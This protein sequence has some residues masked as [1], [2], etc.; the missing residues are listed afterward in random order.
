MWVGGILPV[1][2]GT[3]R[4]FGNRQSSTCTHLC[5]VCVGCIYLATFFVPLPARAEG[6]VV[7]CNTCLYGLPHFLGAFFCFVF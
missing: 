6:C 4:V 2:V 3:R 5:V 7:G 1:Q